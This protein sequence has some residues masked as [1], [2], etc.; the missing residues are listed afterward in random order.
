MDY[1]CDDR[2]AEHGA[3]PALKVLGALE[4]A[5]DPVSSVS[6]V[7]VRLSNLIWRRR[8]DTRTA[9]T[10]GKTAIISRLDDRCTNGADSAARLRG[11]C[12]VSDPSYQNK[13]E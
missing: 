3:C 8:L 1:L 10:L 5:V 13:D 9:L 4:S 12:N 7:S 6:F 11:L 2:T